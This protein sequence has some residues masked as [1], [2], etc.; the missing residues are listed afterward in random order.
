MPRRT[1]KTEAK[2]PGCRPEQEDRTPAPD[3]GGLALD[4]R[5]MG[6]MG[7]LAGGLA[8]DFNHLMG[9]ILGYCETLEAEPELPEPIRKTILEIHNAGLSARSLAQR[10][11]AS[12]QRKTPERMALNLN[13]AVRRMEGILARLVGEKGELVI[14]LSSGL[15]TIHADPS[16]IDQ[17][18]MNLAINAGDAMPQG[19]RIVLETANVEIDEASNRQHPSVR[20]G[21]Y[22]M[23]TVSDMGQGMDPETQSRIFEPFFSTKPPGQGTGLGLSTVS[24]IVK[25]Y[26][27]AIGV[28]SQPGAG[29]TF[30]VYFP[31]AAEARTALRLG[32]DTPLPCGV[33]TI[34]V[35]DDSA[36][37]RSLMKRILE[38]KGYRVQELGDPAQAL[39]WA[40]VHKGPLPL[41]ITDLVMPEFS[42][43]VLAERVA[44]LRPE[45]RVLFVTGYNDQSPESLGPLGRHCALLAKPFTRGDLLRKVRQILDLS[46]EA[47]ARPSH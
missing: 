34:L 32:K 31:R 45:T 44:S 38:E 9:V 42:G 25:Q 5:D 46:E 28:S 19:G 8:H 26:G 4:A 39:R 43:A 40:E 29:T 33:E 23:L 7:Q 2:E 11:L 13:Q 24:G 27:G 21:N 3:E 47:S 36:A 17:V 41:L 22:V 30:K 10:L 12:S 14:S 16:E 1:S 37:L 20:P 6:L 15:G 18:L 35:V